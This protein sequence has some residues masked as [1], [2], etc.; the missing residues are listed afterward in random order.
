M[1]SN[2]CVGADVEESKYTKH[3]LKIYHDHP[4]Y[5]TCVGADVERLLY[6]TSTTDN[7]VV[8]QEHHL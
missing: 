7:A 1:F 5:I 3:I 6:R 2:T 8:P 4:I